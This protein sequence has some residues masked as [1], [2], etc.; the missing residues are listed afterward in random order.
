VL[1]TDNSLS[2]HSLKLMQ[3]RDPVKLPMNSF[4]QKGA[5]KHIEAMEKEAN[6]C[7]SDIVESVAESSNETT[8]LYRSLYHMLAQ[9]H[10][11]HTSCEYVPNNPFDWDYRFPTRE[12]AEGE[13]SL[14][15]LEGELASKP[16]SQEEELL[17]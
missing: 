8:N 2:E 14:S 12:E 6:V 3:G 1:V 4:V 7:F 10:V 16:A 17:F 15:E 11:F 9:R 5:R 13:V